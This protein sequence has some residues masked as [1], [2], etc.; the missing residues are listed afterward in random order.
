MR[1]SVHALL[2]ENCRLKKVQK[3]DEIYGDPSEAYSGLPNLI[4]WA[5][6]VQRIA[7]KDM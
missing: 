7:N 2:S 5:S 4:G 6:Y 1:D 3:L